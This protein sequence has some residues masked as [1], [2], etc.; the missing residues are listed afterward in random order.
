MPEIRFVQGCMGYTRTI[1]LHLF[2]PSMLMS[3][4]CC[5]LLLSFVLN[6][7]SL[8]TYAHAHSLPS[9]TYFLGIGILFLTLLR[10]YVTQLLL[11]CTGQAWFVMSEASPGIWE[12][13]AVTAFSYL[14]CVGRG[15]NMRLMRILYNNM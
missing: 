6:K 13:R 2:I 8:N 15:S 11:W 1:Y 10:S 5:P 4:V 12:E 3:H 9:A 14:R 7:L